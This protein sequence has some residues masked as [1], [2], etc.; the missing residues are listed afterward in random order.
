MS[1]VASAECNRRSPLAEIREILSAAPGCDFKSP[2]RLLK[3]FGEQVAEVQ[4]ILI[5][6][7]SLLHDQAGGQKPL[8]AE[9]IILKFYLYYTS[10]ILEG[11]ENDLRDTQNKVYK[12]KVL[13]KSPLNFTFLKTD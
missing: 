1:A 10:G 13:E 8:T 4:R 11:D 12:M 2:A 5:P 6:R 3:M 9:I 7:A